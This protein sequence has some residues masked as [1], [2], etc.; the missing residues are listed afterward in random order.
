MM[1]MINHL[2]NSSDDQAARTDFLGGG[3]VDAMRWTA[4]DALRTM[5]EHTETPL[6]ALPALASL[7]AML[8]SSVPYR[9]LTT[10]SLTVPPRADGTVP[11]SV[12]IRIVQLQQQQQQ[13]PDAFCRRYRSDKNNTRNSA[14]ADKPARRV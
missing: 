1:M 12:M 14:D 4:C 13:V 2:S 9:R 8:R 3:K 10:H 5:T 6:A 11:N 7:Y